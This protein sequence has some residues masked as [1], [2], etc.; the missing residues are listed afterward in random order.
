MCQLPGKDYRERSSYDYGTGRKLLARLIVARKVSAARLNGRSTT[1]TDG[2]PDKPAVQ[3]KLISATTFIPALKFKKMEKASSWLSK[4]KYLVIHRPNYVNAGPTTTI[5]IVG[6][7]V[8]G[9][10]DV[11][12]HF[13]ISQTGDIIQMV[14]LNDESFHVKSS[15]VTNQNSVGIELEGGVKADGYNW[16]TPDPQYKAVAEVLAALRD[17]CGWED[18]KLE[19]GKNGRGKPTGRIFGHQDLQDGRYDPGL[20]FDYDKVLKM[21]NAMAKQPLTALIE[22]KHLID[23]NAEQAL[24]EMAKLNAEVRAPGEKVK[25]DLLRQAVA[26]ELRNREVLAQSR[27]T[28]WSRSEGFTNA[29]TAQRQRMNAAIHSLTPPDLPKRVQI[30]QPCY[31]WVS[32]RWELPGIP[33]VK[34][35]G[36]SG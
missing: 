11:S 2:K 35:E 15:G 4:I 32:G 36:T 28:L 16:P 13:V 7:F 21:A 27:A 30:H 25:L 24:V 29:F 31:N 17:A 8:E 33:V 23:Q 19:K 14:D 34:V 6:T 20:G 12:T 10:K 26:S 9:K 18:E 22:S 5:G 3:A 1:T